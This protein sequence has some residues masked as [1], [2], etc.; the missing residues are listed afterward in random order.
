MIAQQPMGA[1]GVVVNHS[2]MQVSGPAYP[3]G[4]YTPGAPG[5][6]YYPGAQPMYA[7]QTVTHDKAP[8]VVWAILDQ[9]WTLLLGDAYILYNLIVTSF[10][11]FV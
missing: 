11:A 7:E 8:L 9:P 5:P 1:P 2:S 3:P 6:V 4:A 10:A